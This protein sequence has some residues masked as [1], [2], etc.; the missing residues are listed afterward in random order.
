[1]PPSSTT[2]A[3]FLLFT[4][5][6]PSTLRDLLASPC[7]TPSTP[8]FHPLGHSLARQLTSAVAHLHSHHIAHRDLAPANI[9]LSST[10]AP[11]LIDFGISLTAGDEAPGAMFF[12][13]GTG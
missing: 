7:F 10:G 9:A 13:V 2:S 4:P 5:L 8:S 6:Y 11:V 12:E 3:T 1:M